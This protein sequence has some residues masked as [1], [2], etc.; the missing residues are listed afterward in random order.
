MI[1]PEFENDRGILGYAISDPHVMLATP[2]EEGQSACISYKHSYIPCAPLSCEYVV[3]LI[4]ISIL[5]DS[6][7]DCED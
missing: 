2:L 6:L 3:P 5:F 7:I 4:M 1:P